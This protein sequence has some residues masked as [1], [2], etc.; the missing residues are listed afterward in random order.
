[1]A[2]IE[3]LWPTIEKIREAS[4]EKLQDPAWLEYVL[5]PELGLNDRHMHQYPTHL[6]PFCGVGI[7][8]W[9]YPNQF[10]KYLH[11][12]SKQN[13]ESYIEIGC[14]KGGTFIITVE[15]LSRFHPIAR[16][17]AVDNWER[18]IMHEYANINPAVSYLPQS[19]QSD[20]F[21]FIVNSQHWDLVLVDG[22]HSYKGVVEDF[23]L[24]KGSAKRIAFHDIR[25]HLCPGTQ[26]IWF[27]IKKEYSHCN[28]YEW[29]DQY[30]DVLLRLR[31]GIMGIGLL[32]T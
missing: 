27:E 13:L 18:E 17:V 16:A 5:L 2:E 21:K 32:E 22:D 30:D 12:L 1:M 19:S 9:Q 7:D 23:A 11:Y 20:E 25:N 28:L 10:S 29:V 26:Q 6:H 8:S 15:I 4:L 31:G 14:H 24:V 3:A